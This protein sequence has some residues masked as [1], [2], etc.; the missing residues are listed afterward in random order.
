MRSSVF[1][2]GLSFARTRL[3]EVINWPTSAAL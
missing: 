2:A 3:A 1:D